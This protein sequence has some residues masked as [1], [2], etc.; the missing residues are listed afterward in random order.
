MENAS[1]A[2]IMAGSVLI[3]VLL[4]SLIAYIFMQYG[5][6][7]ASIYDE[8]EQ[9]KIAAFNAQFLKYYGT[10]VNSEGKQQQILCTAHD[11][12]SLSNLAKYNNEEQELSLT[13][14]SKSAN[15]IQI[16]IQG[17][18]NNIE[19]WKEGD[20]ITF[21]KNNSLNGNSLKYYVCTEAIVSEI[22]HR[23]CYMNFKTY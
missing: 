15:Y 1:K 10:T 5:S 8:I 16:D 6:Q 23:V 12:V 3:G 22:T 13:Q 20:Q 4:L 2:L 21:I 7:S 19:K 9:N 17:V 18:K 11:L 14:Y